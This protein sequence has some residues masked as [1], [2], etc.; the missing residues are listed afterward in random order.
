M[1][2]A[3]AARGDWP[4]W[5]DAMTFIKFCGMTRAEDVELAC[6]L[7]VDALGFV[8]WSGSPRGID[9]GRAAGL[10]AR[11]PARVSAV[12]VFV[13]PS[14][15]EIRRALDA[16]VR[17]VQIHGV[18]WPY[19]PA[20]QQGAPTWVAATTEADVRAIP[21]EVTVLLDAHDPVRYGGTGRTIDWERAAAVAAR[22]RV[23]LAGGLTP[24]NV[25]D[26]VRRVRPFG[27]DVASGIEERPGVKSASAMRAFVA[28]AREVR[29]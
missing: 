12:G 29:E 23:V 9:A 7:G 5:I 19:E 20:R 24:S 3:D 15:D 10:I 2:E 13:A 4:W 25:R 14:A 28:A 21:D 16:G 27:V 8:L 26:A 6:E 17:V 11:L 1:A 22:R 18:G